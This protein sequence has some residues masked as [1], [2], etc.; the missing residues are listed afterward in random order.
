MRS[1]QDYMMLMAMVVVI[2]IC[3]AGLSALGLELLKAEFTQA[4]SLLSQRP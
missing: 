1:L 4:V 2:A 3:I